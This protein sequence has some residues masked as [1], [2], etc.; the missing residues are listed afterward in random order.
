MSTLEHFSQNLREGLDSLTEG[1]HQLWQ[2]TRQAITRFTPSEDHA[3][4]K[5]SGS[6]QQ[7]QWG[8]LSADVLE[9]DQEIKV[10]LEAP[11]MSTEDFQ[12]SIDN[13]TLSIRGEKHYQRDGTQGQHHVSERAYGRFE[14]VVPLPAPV[15]SSGTRATY[16][17]GVL[18]IT[19]PKAPGAMGRR[20]VIE[21]DN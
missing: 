11:G 7:N 8:V 13:L 9:T 19:A 16:R 4:N 15:D 14:R 5:A 6:R 10:Q 12:I 17:D 3:A 20:I 1:W 18:S 2:K 21:D